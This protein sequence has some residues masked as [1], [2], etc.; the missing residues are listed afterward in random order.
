MPSP[1]FD[2]LS[3]GLKTGQF[4]AKSKASMNWYRGQAQDV[5]KVSRK[6]FIK[7]NTF[8][9]DR[10]ERA[11][12]RAGIEVGSMYIYNYDPKHKKTLPVYDTH[13]IVVP[14]TVLGDRFY[15]CNLHY[16]PP[17]GRAQLMDILHTITNNEE[18]DST[19]K[20]KITYQVLKKIA[21]KSL[22]EPTIHCYLKK[23]IKSQVMYV[24]PAE[25]DMAIFLPIAKF[26]GPRADDYK[27]H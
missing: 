18:Y 6:G 5:A 19:T 10:K 16:L 2:I 15:G 17:G 9:K 24:Y 1:F 26:R 13:P 11:G 8:S 14:F 27:G 12:G 25:W 4:P 22:Y 3:K 20:M 23:H 7:N 21:S